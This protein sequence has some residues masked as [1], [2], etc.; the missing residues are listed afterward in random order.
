MK[1]NIHFFTLLILVFPVL[2]NAQISLPG[3][4]EVPDPLVS[5]SLD[6]T[7]YQPGENGVLTVVYRFPQN[8]HQ[9][10][11]DANFKLSAGSLEGILFGSTVYPEGITE[12]GLINYYDEAEVK[13]EFFISE[14]LS[15]GSY[16]IEIQADFQLCDDQGVCYFPGSI[17]LEAEITVAGKAVSHNSLLY[18]LLLA[19][20]GGILLNLMPC[21]LPLLSVKALNLINQSQGNRRSIMNN[22]LSYTAGIIA[23]FFAISL[24]IIILQQSG[25]LLGWGFQFQNPYFLIILIS[26]I[27]LFSLSLFEVFV[28]LPPS[29]GLNKAS[30]LSSRK[31][32]M[33]SFFTGVFAV[34]V[35]TPCTAPF[36]G[37]AMGFAFS[38]TPLVII[39]IMIAT[40]LGL[41][42]PFL[43]LGFFPDFFKHM[44]KPGKWMDKFREFMA[45]LLM[46]TAV[47]LSSTLIR[48][49]GDGFIP[50]LWFLLI[51]ALTAW[52]WG[53]VA[54]SA[55]KRKFRLV[56][57]TL[58]VAVIV[59]SAVWLLKTPENTGEA[60]TYSSSLHQNWKSFSPEKIDKL[61]AENETVFLAFSASWCTT[62]KIN[63]RTVLYT[64]E[65]DGL[66]ESKNVHLFKADLT[67][68]NEEAM[69]WIY[70]F[71]RA[72]VPLYILYKPGEDPR[73]LPEIL[74]QSLLES[75]LN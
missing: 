11:D 68:T 35:A 37:A 7:N 29:G 60:R 3:A 39:S 74:S 25:A 23:S 41:S 52:G 19:F 1:K 67:S 71:D 31:G 21:V 72:G 22:A 51:L 13:L 15:Q 10:K 9:T 73:I 63:E 70:S 34:F 12:E 47:Y 42:L 64:D 43:I 44:P 49:I 57:N 62:C 53:W 32:Y 30:K 45:F 48:Q 26:V 33:G 28:L 20:M 75:Y 18:F 16:K 36:L 59:F 65:A 14:N 50:F 69:E 17:P 54:R 61:R 27:F 55:R 6:S 58:G 8:F 56:L 4:L 40:G 46:G 5:I 2:L 38:Q 66:F 24:V